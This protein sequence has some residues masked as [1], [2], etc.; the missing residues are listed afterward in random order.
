MRS[1][2]F[3]FFW[4]ILSV[5][6]GQNFILKGKVYDEQGL[7]LPFAIISTADTAYTTN[8]DNEGK[9]E[10]S[11]PAKQEVILEVIYFSQVIKSINVKLEQDQTL[12]INVSMESIDLDPL[13][14]EREITKREEVSAIKIDN[15]VPKRVVSIDGDFNRVLATL[16]PVITASELSSAYAVRGGNYDE[17]LVYVNGVE[18]YRPFLVGAGQQEGLSFVNPDMVE[19]VVFYA[20]GWQPQFGDKLSSVLDIKYKEPEKT[21]ASATVGFLGGSVYVGGASENK[22]V[23]Y[24]LGA[25]HKTTTFLLNSLETQGQY[26]PRFYDVQSYVNVNL[27]KEDA[28]DS[29]ESRTKIGV[30]NFYS[31]N[32]YSVIP[33]ERETTFSTQTDFVRLFIA[34]DGQEKMDYDVYQGAVMLTHQYNKN[35]KGYFNISYMRTREQEIRDVEGGYRLC[36]VGVNV[37]TNEIL[38]ECVEERGVGTIYEYARNTLE[39]NIV[40]GNYESHWHPGGNEDH[41]IT[42][43]ASYSQEVINDVLNEYEFKDSSN[44]VTVTDVRSAVN[45]MN[46]SRYAAFLQHGWWLSDNKKLTYG[47]RVGYWNFTE[48]FIFSPRMQFSW[49]PEKED[50]KDVLYKAAV[51]IYKQ[52]PF[53][54]EL[55]NFSGEV[56]PK[57][58]SQSSLHFIV[59][60]DQ[61]VTIWDRSFKFTSEVYYKYLWNVIPYDLD[62]V[63][64]RYYGDNIATA[65]AY[66]L[67][68]R[69]AGEFVKGEESWFGLSFL[70]TREDVEGDGRGYIRR[71]MDQ[72]VTFTFFFQDYIP[73]HAT[74]KLHMN[75]V[76]GTG[77]PFGPPNDVENRNTFTSPQYRRLD[78]GFSKIVLF[79]DKDVE[80]RKGL[81]SLFFTLE[82]LNILGTSNTISYTWVEDIQGTNYAVPNTLTARFLNLKLTADF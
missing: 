71:P 51:G 80:G 59:G 18:V 6:L 19:E 8:T 17:N 43:G 62:N 45:N 12:D 9:Y 77:L 46:T 68:L 66:G 20:G 41:K 33:E 58:K 4:C 26:K 54:R 73:N 32:S 10:L 70:S 75:L 36:D 42:F 55:R 37:L 13:E 78:V 31:N 30:L 67:D 72:R 61:N 22:K 57:L 53:Y 21:E 16:G 35:H 52:P 47:A 2:L 79:K 7:P 81:E 65:Y 44:Y 38:N 28:F 5:A 50:S 11:L 29:G 74:W 24:T 15:L 23:N 39:A 64:I 82:V 14:I 49:K 3:L 56:N 40:K 34:F 76:Y 25:R 27:G 48:E 1:T 69:L 63:Q 60:R